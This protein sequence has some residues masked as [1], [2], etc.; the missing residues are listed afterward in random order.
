MESDNLGISINESNIE[1]ILNDITLSL[2]HLSP[3]SP[4][5]TS[6]CLSDENFDCSRTASNLLSS[7]QSPKRS[8][9]C[10][11]W[12]HTR[13]GHGMRSSTAP[14]VKCT[15]C[16]NNV[17]SEYGRCKPCVCLWHISEQNSIQS[18]VPYSIVRLTNI[19][20]VNEYLLSLIGK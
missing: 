13:I 3:Q 8:P 19:N 14:Y 6:S 5:H 1:N 18:I 4:P 2:M 12:Q 9:H 17:C 10:S 16:P 11:T 7:V 15:M 20:N